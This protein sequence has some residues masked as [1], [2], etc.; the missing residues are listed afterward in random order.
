[1]RAARDFFNLSPG[2]DWWNARNRR[3][4]VLIGLLAAI[5]L[6]ALIWLAII[7]PLQTY[8]KDMRAGIS[9]H[10][11][12]NAALRRAGPALR[13]STADSSAPA[14][15]IIAAT[16]ARYNLAIVRIAPEEDGNR[17]ELQSVDYAQLIR[18]LADL[19]KNA[20]LHPATIEI[21]RADGPGLVHVQMMLVL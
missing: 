17:I 12:L 10:E 11:A 5:A 1:M 6:I 8:R 15:A 14:A 13:T 20:G 19:D 7:R 18:W 9:R 16:A 4:Q 3:E 2:K 21:T